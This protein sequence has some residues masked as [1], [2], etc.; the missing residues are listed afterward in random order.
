MLPLKFKYQRQEYWASKQ[1]AKDAGAISLL[2]FSLSPERWGKLLN[3]TGGAEWN[4]QES[5]LTLGYRNV[6][7]SPHLEQPR[8]CIQGLLVAE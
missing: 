3:R 1:R 8:L 2:L 6:A 7:L 4:W 5:V